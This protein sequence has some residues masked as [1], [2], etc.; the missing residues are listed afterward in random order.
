[1]TASGVDLAPQGI[2][3]RRMTSLRG[4]LP[5][6]ESFP[7]EHAIMRKHFSRNSTTAE[8]FA[9]RFPILVG[10]MRFVCG[11]LILPKQRHKRS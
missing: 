4:H 9:V 11:C 8:N 1:M 7:V 10:A 5:D 6:L 3:S 2:Y